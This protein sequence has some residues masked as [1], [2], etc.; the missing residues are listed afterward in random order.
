M[1]PF[2]TCHRLGQRFC[3][4]GQPAPR[5]I[6]AW[7]RAI[8]AI[9]GSALVGGVAIS[10]G[11]LTGCAA[12]SNSPMA[13]ALCVGAQQPRL[14]LA[15]TPATQAPPPPPAETDTAR[16]SGTPSQ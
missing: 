11:F 2:L 6:L 5:Q 3:R 12:P 1:N 10:A 8:D 14:S 13:S 9:G 16:P 7:R 15:R 4:Q